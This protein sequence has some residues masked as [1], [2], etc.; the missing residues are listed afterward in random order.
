M[1]AGAG[2]DA[3]VHLLLTW[4]HHPAHADVQDGEALIRAAGGGHM[5]VVRMLLGAP[6]H[7][8]S[9]DCQASCALVR[10]CDGGHEGVVRTLLTWRERPAAADG[11]EGM[12]LVRHECNP[13]MSF[14]ISLLLILLFCGTVSHTLR[15][16][17]PTLDAVT[18]GA[19]GGRGARE[20]RA[21]AAHVARAA[22]GGGHTRRPGA[23]GGRVE[24]AGGH[25]APASNLG[26]PPASRRLPGGRGAHHGRRCVLRQ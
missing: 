26:Q 5:G 3:V 22:G 24:G 12:A 6:A 20:R 15:L 16:T 21:D 2:R 11:Q 18:T 14:L 19:C 25:H 9:A 7:A 4:P 23:R 1:A 10:A 13:F 8:A 17:A